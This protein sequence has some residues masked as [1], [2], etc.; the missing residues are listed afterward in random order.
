MIYYPIKN[1]EGLY[2]ISKSGKIRSLDRYT[3][4]KGHFRKGKEI[5]CHYECGYECIMI[6]KDKKKKHNLVH[7]LMAKTFIPN[8]E[9]KRTVN[10]IDGNKLNNNLS[11][12]EWNTHKENI[13]HSYKMGMSNNRGEG[14]GRAKLTEKDVFFMRKSYGK[15]GITYLSL[16]KKFNIT[17]AV[18]RFA[19]KGITWKYL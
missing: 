17:M 5:K 19:V 2:E 14:N 7:R 15:D 6:S 9:N 18:A 8:P 11:N 16:A 4:K 13:A 12:L 3:H 10:H 1:Y